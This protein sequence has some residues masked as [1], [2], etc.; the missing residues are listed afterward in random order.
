[1]PKINKNE[2]M[3]LI[4]SILGVVVALTTVAV[5]MLYSS[6]IIRADATA[7]EVSAPHTAHDNV[8][9]SSPIPDAKLMFTNDTAFIKQWSDTPYIL[10]M[11]QMPR[12]AE[13]G[14]PTQF[15]FNLLSTNHT[16]SS[17]WLWHSDMSITI[18]NSNGQV[19]LANPNLHGHGSML[20]FLYVFPTAGIY[21][22]DVLYGQQTGSPNFF[23]SPKVT[24]Q[25]NF[26]VTVATPQPAP[27]L[28]SGAAVKEIPISVQSFAFTP[29]VI[30]VNKG[31]L[32][33]LAFT[34]AEDDANLYN[35]HGFGIE[36]YNV[37]A[38]LTKGSRQTVEFLAD[39]PGTFTFRCTSFC[40][41][42]G[43]DT[44]H[45]Y[46]MTGQLVVHG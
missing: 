9:A 37:N 42:P 25:A 40:V 45:H 44:I 34:V 43:G 1:M 19:V 16:G 22:V 4:I 38:F 32:V 18:T 46:Q 3:V 28:P 2:G 27:T 24:H 36:K 31:D 30:N 23:L 11:A 5:A 12:V 10:D 41:E 29:N 8:T 6:D 39:K 15:V 26:D 17:T 33:R 21:N 35:G 7:V 20:Q 13:A 14:K